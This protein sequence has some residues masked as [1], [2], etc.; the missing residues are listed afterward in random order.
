MAQTQYERMGSEAFQRGEPRR[1]PEGIV[2]WQGKPGET[3]LTPGYEWY[4]G[5]DAANLAA[6]LPE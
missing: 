2:R 3:D 6:P 5:W 4:R 1:M